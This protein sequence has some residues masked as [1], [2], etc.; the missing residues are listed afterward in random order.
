ME[1]RRR[2]QGTGSGGRALL[3]LC[4]AVG[5]LGGCEVAPE[6]PPPPPPPVI[7]SPAP[8]RP[9]PTYVPCPDT[10]IQLSWRLVQDGFDVECL[11]GDTVSVRVDS[12]RMIADFPCSDGAGVTP[13][14]EGGVVH[15][16]SF[17]LTDGDGH[18]LSQTGGIDLGVACGGVTV[19]PEVDV[20]L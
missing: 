15:D 4:A 2:E 18:V 6:G 17:A 3:A 1:R 13:P 5:L 12:D 10:Q 14:L 9:E 11:P 20:H 16:L 8:P 19:G 7:D